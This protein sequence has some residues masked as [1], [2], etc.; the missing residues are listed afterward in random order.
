MTISDP[1]VRRF[2]GKV[3]LVTGAANG[4]GAAC[5]RRLAAE[6]SRLALSD[7]DEDGLA[8]VL[9]DVRTTLGDEQAAIAVPCD[10]SAEADVKSLFAQL[11]AHHERLDVVVNMAGIIG[12]ANSH[13]ETL[14]QW[15]RIIG[16]NLTGLFLVCR[17]AIPHLVETKGNI[18]NA[19]STASLSGHP[20]FTA[21][22][23]SKGGVLMLTKSLA[24]EYAKRGMRVNA[25]APGGITTNM[26]SDVALPSEVD[27]EI[28]ARMTPL[29]DFGMPETVADA[30]AFLASDDARYVNGEYLRVDGATLA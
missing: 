27:Y 1:G 10:I 8:K 13:E 20:W 29:G 7:V 17:E 30:V 21:Y 16:V 23:A 26:T 5:A 2:N 3:A 11:I 9:A 15:N 22:G 25:V 18:V 4:I 14:E 24:M 28:L 6:G 19:A 12:T